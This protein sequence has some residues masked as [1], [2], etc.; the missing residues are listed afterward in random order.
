[1][2][3]Y[4]PT[5]FGKIHNAEAMELSVQAGAAVLLVVAL[6]AH[7]TEVRAS[8]LHARNALCKVSWHSSNSNSVDC[9]AL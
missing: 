5:E 2:S 8:V 7:V 1:V 3:V 9:G 4:W 6:A